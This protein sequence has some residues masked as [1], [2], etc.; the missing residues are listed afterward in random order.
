MHRLFTS[1]EYKFFI[2][3]VDGVVCEVD[4][5]FLQVFLFGSLVR[6]RGK[7]SQALL[8]NI[9]SNRVRP[10]DQNVQAHVEF[11]TIYQERV[12]YIGL[13]NACPSFNLLDTRH[14]SDP[15]P[16]TPC[17][18]LEYIDH[19]VLLRLLGVKTHQLPQLG[20]N[21]PGGGK[22]VVLKRKDLAHLHEAPPQE[23]L[24]R[25]DLYRGKVTDFLMVVE[26]EEILGFD[27]VVGPHYVPNLRPFRAFYNPAQLLHNHFDDVVVC[28]LIEEVVLERLT[29]I[30][31]GSTFSIAFFMNRGGF[32][33][34]SFVDSYS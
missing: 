27:M 32:S 21:G 25:E 33:F 24:F 20:R 29:T 1:I 11:E 19:L 6:L 10:V 18:G 34:F 2:V 5:V 26:L 7:P 9:Y 12:V 14:Q 31:L 22:E 28:F 3:L 13:Y 4:V 17:L 30:S 15:L 16:L 23:V 8:V